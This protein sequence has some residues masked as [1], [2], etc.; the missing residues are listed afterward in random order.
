M[1]TMSSQIISIFWTGGFDSTY[2]LIDLLLSGYTVEPIYIAKRIDGRFSIQRERKTMRK[3]R[4]EIIKTFPHAKEAFLKTV[5]VRNLFIPETLA[6]LVRDI[7]FSGKNRASEWSVE[8][9]YAHHVGQKAQLGKQY[10]YLGLVSL[11]HP[12][13]IEMSITNSP[14]RT[15]DFFKPIIGKGRL[16]RIDPAVLKDPENEPR[17][18]FRNVRFPIIDM[19]K[20]DMFKDAEKKGYVHLLYNTWSCWGKT[21]IHA[22][23]SCGTCRN[24]RK[25]KK[26]FQEFQALSAGQ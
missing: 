9:G 4:S 26:Y 19:S 2:R 3:L 18:L 15:T 12:R 5:Q 24:C 11:M 1:P 17:A 20:L 6:K 8:S 22:N 14:G 23:E 13:P 10:L 21:D 7:G 25:R 16:K